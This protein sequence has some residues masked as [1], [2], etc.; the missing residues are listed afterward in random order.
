MNKPSQLELVE[1]EI[2]NHWRRQ[3]ATSDVKSPAYRAWKARAMELLDKRNRLFRT[4][5]DEDPSDDNI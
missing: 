4:W 1:R 2:A 5:S 3:P